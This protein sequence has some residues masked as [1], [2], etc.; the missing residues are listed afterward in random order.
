METNV[1][2]T[3]NR[4]RERVSWGQQSSKA[5]EILQRASSTYFKKSVR[6]K[7]IVVSD[8]FLQKGEKLV[9]LHVPQ[10][11][12]IEASRNTEKYLR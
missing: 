5:D 4:W 8:F 3:Y 6:E 11:G 7:E 1:T 2:L 9:F 10:E 12:K